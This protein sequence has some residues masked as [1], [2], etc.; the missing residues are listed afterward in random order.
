MSLTDCNKLKM[1]GKESNFFSK[2]HV[3]ESKLLLFK[4][5]G[6]TGPQYSVSQTV[7]RDPVLVGSAEIER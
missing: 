4:E 7:R 6:G 1:S 5:E 3:G 2:G